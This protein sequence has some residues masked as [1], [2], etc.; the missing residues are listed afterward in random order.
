M[1]IPSIS[2]L[3]MKTFFSFTQVI[4][5]CFF[6][7]KSGI[8]IILLLVSTVHLLSGCGSSEKA[9][10]IPD[11]AAAPNW[12][13]T[14]EAKSEKLN[15]YL[16]L[17]A[18]ADVKGKQVKIVHPDTTVKDSGSVFIGDIAEIA[19][20]AKVVNVYT[21][22]AAQDATKAYLNGASQPE[23][24]ESG[25]WFAEQA[26]TRALDLAPKAAERMDSLS[27]A[28]SILIDQLEEEVRKLFTSPAL[29]PKDEI[30]L[31]GLLEKMNVLAS[32][33]RDMINT[34]AAE[35]LSAGTLFSSPQNSRE[36]A[37]SVQ[38]KGIRFIDQMMEESRRRQD[39]LG[40]VS[41]ALDEQS[42]NTMTDH[43]DI[44]RSVSSVYATISATYGKIADELSRKKASTLP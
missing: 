9:T 25:L 10:R 2:K 13:K 35:Y 1:T 3:H 21:R 5:P 6:Y 17:R 24:S 22:T 20:L 30:Y 26:T 8:W 36:N 43:Q 12:F 19:Y 23:N 39:R 18:P 42:Q 15:N 44:Y 27:K 16:Q 29:T 11:T 32:T 34:A 7:R 38:S 28:G 40:K 31:F 14:A 41:L 33:H 4:Q 37:I